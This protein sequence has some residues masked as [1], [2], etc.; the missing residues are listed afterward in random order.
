[1]R[2]WNDE[3]MRPPINKLTSAPDVTELTE[4]VTGGSHPRMVIPQAGDFW[5]HYY[6]GTVKVI[7]RWNNRESICELPN[8]KGRRLLHD[9]L[10]LKKV[11]AV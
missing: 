6:H 5:Q 1:M 9:D 3:A 10:M 8:G 4:D 2:L 11:D 7:R